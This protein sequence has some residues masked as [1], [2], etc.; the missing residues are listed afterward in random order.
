MDWKN[1]MLHI[2]PEP[3]PVPVDDDLDSPRDDGEEDKQKPGQEVN[4]RFNLCSCSSGS[5]KSR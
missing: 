5:L 3:Q 4:I 2:L 1:F